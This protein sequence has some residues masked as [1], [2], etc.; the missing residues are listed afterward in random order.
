MHGGSTAVF[1]LDAAVVHEFKGKDGLDFIS[2][3]TFQAIEN[4]RIGTYGQ[5]T[6]GVNIVTVGALSG[7]AEGDAN[8]GSAFK[9]GGGR[10]GLS[11]KF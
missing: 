1:Y 2:G 6:L 9:G 3:G 7:F 4:T 11:V 5:G 8:L 10:I